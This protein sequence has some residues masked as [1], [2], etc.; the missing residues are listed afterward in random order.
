MNLPGSGLYL[1]MRQW[2]ENCNILKIIIKTMD[3]DFRNIMRLV[4]IL[5]VVIAKEHFQKVPCIAFEI[6]I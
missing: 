5:E 4:N 1:D 6:L 2:E 3:K